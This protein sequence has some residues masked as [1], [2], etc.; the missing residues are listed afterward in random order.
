MT[1]H[2]LL[3]FF[4]A[5]GVGLIAYLILRVTRGRLATLTVPAFLRAC[6]LDITALTRSFA[7]GRGC[8]ALC[9]LYVVDVVLLLI[10]FPAGLVSILFTGALVVIRLNRLPLDDEPSTGEFPSQIPLYPPNRP[11]PAP[12]ADPWSRPALHLRFPERKP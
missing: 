6:L 2:D 12:S 11:T 1:A 10:S 3:I 4:I 7:R 8:L 5:A 9:A